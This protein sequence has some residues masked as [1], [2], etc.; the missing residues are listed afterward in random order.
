MRKK[1]S[2]MNNNNIL[3]EGFLTKLIQS[4]V[5]RPVTIKKE[6]VKKLEK[7]LEASNKKQEQLWDDFK[8]LMKKE[9]GVNVKRGELKKKINKLGA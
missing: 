3:S 9:Y 7:D 2:Y 4:F 6:K 5:S 8:V 1:R